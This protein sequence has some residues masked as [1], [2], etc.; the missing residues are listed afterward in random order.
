MSSD[1]CSDVELRSYCMARREIH[2][3]EH[4]DQ[5]LRFRRLFMI[6]ADRIVKNG[7]MELWNFGI[8]E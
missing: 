1:I 4:E 5:E 6:Y 8:L 7:I 3:E 2:H